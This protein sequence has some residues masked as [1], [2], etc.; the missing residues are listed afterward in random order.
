MR[1]A[2]DGALT[3]RDRAAREVAKLIE[4]AAPSRLPAESMSE[5][6]RLMEREARR[7]GMDKLPASEP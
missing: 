2:K 7:Y 1:W 5:L 3:L 4:R 6:V